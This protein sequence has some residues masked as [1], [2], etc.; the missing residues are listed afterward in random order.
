[1][2]AGIERL[3]DRQVKN[4]KKSLNDGGNLWILKRGESKLW[5]FRYT[6][7]GKARKAGLGGYPTVTL[8]DA[9]KVALSY[10]KLIHNGVDPIDEANRLKREYGR[11]VPTFNQAAARYILKQRHEWRNKKHTKQWISTIRN[12]ANPVI[13]SM[14]VTDISKVEVLKILKPIWLTKTETAKRIQGRIENILDWCIAMDYTDGANPAR[15]QG[16]LDKLLQSPAKIKKLNNNGIERHHPAM[17]YEEVP[18]FYAELKAK[19]GFSVKALRFLILTACRSG[20]VLNATWDEIDIPNKTWTI[21][22][23]RMKAFKEHRVPLTNDMIEI[24][25]SLHVLNEY[26]F[27]GQRA[28]RPQSGVSMNSVMK[29]MGV[30][31]YVPHGFRS[32]FRDWCEEQSTSSYG[33]IERALAHTIPNKTERAYN[34]GDLFNKRRELM[35]S[36][37]DYVGPDN[38]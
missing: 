36:W 4:T 29:K 9:R 23:K 21:S 28:G 8:A 18:E 14:L 3:T 24:L 35:G 33:V 16:N 38:S 27:P 1:M 34:R 37:G 13:G 19:E 11:D 6:M 12:Y 22:A 15:W 26:V 7:Q 5:A 31:Q 17:P 30:G 25:E 32:S 10:R 20:E 2:A